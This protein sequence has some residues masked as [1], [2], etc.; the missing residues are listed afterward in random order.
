MVGEPSLGLSAT[1][2]FRRP[3]KGVALAKKEETGCAVRISWGRR[4]LARLIFV[5]NPSVADRGERRDGISIEK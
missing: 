5:A 4:F 3:E 1:C 2:S